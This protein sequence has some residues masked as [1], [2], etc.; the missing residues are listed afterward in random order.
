MSSKAGNNP[1]LD[2]GECR[3]CGDDVSAERLG[4]GYVLC[5]C[6]GEQAARRVKHTIVP[7]NKS[8]YVYVS[9]GNLTMLA[10]LNPKNTV[11][12]DWKQRGRDLENFDMHTKGV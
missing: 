3:L 10:Q 5:M 1:D 9:P 8:N 12:L 4:L 2:W 11:P 7:M 6:C